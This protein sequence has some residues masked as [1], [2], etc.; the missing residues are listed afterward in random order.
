[1][2][3]G[4]EELL[5]EG[6]SRLP[7]DPGVPAGLAR[8]AR[9]RNRQ[10]R[11][12]IRSAAAAGTAMV[13]A[14]AVIAVTGGPQ[15]S[16]SALREQTI[17]YVTSRTQH[18][19]AAV[20]RGKAIEV[21]HATAHNAVFSFTVLNLAPSRQQNPTGSALFPGVHA[22]R[23]TTWFYRGLVLE[24]GFSAAG[25]HVFSSSIST[26]TSP[27][28]KRV[29]EGYGAAY[30]ART[31]WRTPLIGQA[32]PAPK[33]TCAHAF[34]GPGTSNFR[35]TIAK[36][37]SCK[38]F[39]LDGHQ[40]VSGVNAIKLTLKPQPG[41]PIRQTL[42]VDPSTYLPLRTSTSF[43]AA[44]RPARVLVDDYQWLPPT[45]ANLA[46]LRATVRHA[47]I[48][49]GFRKL[50]SSELPLIGIDTSGTIKP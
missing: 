29:P 31:R 37:L 33:L 46:A 9:Q 3:N 42:W 50:P 48:P 23:T 14:V 43:L 2:T 49:P 41:L 30:P 47:A 15:R 26:V 7:V 34:P 1:M 18:A 8:R 6:I 27:A 28:G 21:V 38:L 5:R 44:Q 39:T 16:S 35:A 20:D 36:A 40:Q 19:L 32:G 22:Q 4:A 12:A 24:E 25:M 10:R 13:A 11:I 17:A 45:T